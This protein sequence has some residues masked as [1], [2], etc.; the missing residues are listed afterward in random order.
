MLPYGWRG[1]GTGMSTAASMCPVRPGVRTNSSPHGHIACCPS[2]TVITWTGWPQAP[3]GTPAIGTRASTGPNAPGSTGL[4]EPGQRRPRS[5][6]SPNRPASTT[7]CAAQSAQSV[8]F[9]SS[10]VILFTYPLASSRTHSGV[11][12]FAPAPGRPRG[13]YAAADIHRRAPA[14]LGETFEHGGGQTSGRAATGRRRATARVLREAAEYLGN[15]PRPPEVLCGPMLDRPFRARR[16]QSRPPVRRRTRRLCPARRPGQDRA[17]G[18]FDSRCMAPSRAGR[19]SFEA[20]PVRQR[21]PKPDQPVRPPRS[22]SAAPVKQPT[23]TRASAGR[24]G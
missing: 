14:L 11:L 16:D 7:G 17:L 24:T 4:P 15:I 18:A 22:S 19:S 21:M 10:G 23:A 6:C 13:R 12:V 9:L 8:T 5:S 1:S 20:V 2:C 3:Q